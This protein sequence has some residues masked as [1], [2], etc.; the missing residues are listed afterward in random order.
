MSNSY[1]DWNKQIIAEFRKNH[2]NVGGNFEGAPL[3][4]LHTVGRRSG[5]PR[6]NPVMYLRDGERYV[7]FASKAG[8]DTHPD[9]YENL[10]ANPDVLIEVVDDTIDV[11][12]EEIDGPERERLYE[13]QASI[14]PNFAEY[15][16]KTKRVIPVIALTNKQK[17]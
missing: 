4:L 16:S 3:L 14:Y 15:Q 1:N 5:K 8:A 17:M 12:A 9:W 11:H 10:K 2:G 7:V 13:R 6:L